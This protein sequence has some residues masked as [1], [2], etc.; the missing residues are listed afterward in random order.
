MYTFEWLTPA[1][2]NDLES[3][4]GPKGAYGGCWCMFW[5][6]KQG[7]FSRGCGEPNR[8]AFQTIVSNGDR[9]GIVAY[10]GQIPVGWMAVGP[11]EI[12]GRLGRSKIL[13]PV[14]GL[15][16][17]SITCFYIAKG[18]RRKGLT[19]ALLEAAVDMVGERGGEVLEGYPVEPKTGKTADIYAYT[20]LASAFRKAGFEEVARR[21]ETRPIMRKVITAGHLRSNSGA[22]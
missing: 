8:K 10:H 6:L 18:Y 15:S 3:L 16:V 12:Y 13:A 5:R 22:G 21:S 1:R 20:G 19:V 11:R 7:D 4:F 9:P 2:W 17:W 14:D